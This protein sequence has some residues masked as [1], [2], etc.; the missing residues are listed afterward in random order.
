MAFGVE[1][2]GGVVA[3]SA[4]CTLS[5]T[6]TAA[7]LMLVAVGIGVAGASFTGVTV[8]YGGVGLTYV[9]SSESTDSNWCGVR[10]FRL[11]NPTPGTANV[12]AQTVGVTQS[13]MHVITFIDANLTL[14]APSISTGSS[15]NPSLTVAASASGDIVVSACVND[16]S[17]VS[18]TV[19]GTNIMPDAT[20]EDVG[21]DTDH[22]SQYQTASGAN[23]V[24][25]W[26]NSQSGTLWAASGLAVKPAAGAA[27]LEQEGFRFRNDDGSETTATWRS[28]ENANSTIPLNT[29]VR[30]RMLVN[31]TG[32]PATAQYQLEWLKVGEG[33]WRKVE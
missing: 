18:T 19:G 30:L 1:S 22:H 25:T 32:D 4:N 12:V 24:C 28:P 7:N 10:W 16:N 27:T 2:V 8:A 33:V 29:N 26:T 21:G 13:S 20:G 23:T 6:V 3:Q 17:G 9:A 14:G 31:A 5:R 11:N 15:A